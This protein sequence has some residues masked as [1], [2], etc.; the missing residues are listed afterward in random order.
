MKPK[1]QKAKYSYFKFQKR[2][3]ISGKQVW[4]NKEHTQEFAFNPGCDSE[5]SITCLEYSEPS[6]EPNSYRVHL[7]WHDDSGYHKDFQTKEELNRFFIVYKD[8]HTI[9]LDELRENW[10][11]SQY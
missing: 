5:L 11:F 9:N 7:G 2:V 1:I 3:G 10:N 4:P 8:K 6:T